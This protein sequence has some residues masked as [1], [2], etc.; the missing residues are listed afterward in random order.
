MPPC[1]TRRSALALLG[2]GAWPAVRAAPPGL[3]GEWTDAARAR[4]V[5]WLLRLPAAGGP[6]PLVVYSHGLGGSRDGGALWGQAWAD[7]GIAVLHLQHPGSDF[8]TLRQGLR[9]LRAAANAQQLL[10]RV[11][12]V[13]FALDE[14]VRRAAA[15]EG[16]WSTL[17][18]DAV[19]VAGHSFGAVTTQAVA[20]QRYPNGQSVDEP[21]P[22]AFI[23]FSPSP[24]AGSAV[25]AFAGVTRPFLAVTG[26]LDGDPFGSYTT[27]EPRAAI[28]DAL[29]AGQRA[30]LWLDGAD[31]ATCGG[32]APSGVPA[33]GLM[34]RAPLALERQ[35]AH[36]ALAAR[37]SAA[38]WR[39]R[40]VGDESAR[41]ALASPEDLG[42]GDR[43]SLDGAR[44]R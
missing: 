23:A 19:G 9:A 38:W 32:G 17:R 24:A 15:A 31:H 26:S 34:R 18:A 10:A 16:P 27:G 4:R 36:Q 21:R 3:T 40:L 35:A 12:D 13:R 44:G 5:P 11:A 29:P 1:F 33:R 41:Q 28:H 42:P 2:A 7:A 8:E 22:R 6:W 39:W 20:G 14:V 37:V 43:F 30:L 25:R